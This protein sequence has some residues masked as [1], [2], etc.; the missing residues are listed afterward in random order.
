MT[1]TGVHP[2]GRACRPLSLPGSR[3]SHCTSSSD[4][5]SQTQPSQWE[6]KH[7][8]IDCLGMIL[9]HIMVN[10][11]ILFWHQ[12]ITENQVLSNTGTVT[13]NHITWL[14]CSNQELLTSHDCRH[15]CCEH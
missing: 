14:H 3:P 13:F 9:Q 1:Y 7:T 10:L 6:L 5:P 11:Q 8:N 12:H 15:Q 2:P 4:V